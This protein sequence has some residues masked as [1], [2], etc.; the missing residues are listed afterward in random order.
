M[1]Y[2]PELCIYF[3]SDCCAKVG[4]EPPFTAKEIYRLTKAIKCVTLPP[5]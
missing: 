5:Q 3:C 4:H 1:V 2:D